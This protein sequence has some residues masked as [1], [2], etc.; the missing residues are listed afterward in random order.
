MLKKKYIDYRF[1]SVQPQTDPS[2]W[3]KAAPADGKRFR[4][5]FAGA[6]ILQRIRRVAWPKVAQ[7]ATLAGRQRDETARW[8][9][10]KEKK[11]MV[12]STQRHRRRRRRPFFPVS[13]SRVTTTLYRVFT[14]FSELDRSFTGSRFLMLL[15][16]WFYSPE[17]FLATLNELYRVL[18]G[19]TGPL[20]ILID[21][22]LEDISQS[23]WNGCDKV[24]TKIR[25][26]PA[27]GIHWRRSK[28]S[29]ARNAATRSASRAR[30]TE[31][32]PGF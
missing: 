5:S 26:R 22:V 3:M 1:L 18:F 17:P 28:Y 27:A 4:G 11:L 19:S 15:L 13:I 25:R 7:K 23:L 12:P 29:S 6:S 2:R 20:W 9:G 21:Y 16:N 14:G 31:F 8:H 32:L 10:K 24:G 30:F